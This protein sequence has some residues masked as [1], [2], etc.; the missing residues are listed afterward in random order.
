[1]YLNL[2]S[3]NEKRNRFNTCKI[4]SW[5]LTSHQSTSKAEDILCI[6]PR[7]RFLT[8]DD[9]TYVHFAVSQLCYILKTSVVKTIIKIEVHE[10]VVTAKLREISNLPKERREI[11]FVKNL[12]ERVCS[13]LKT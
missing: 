10:D 3:T 4:F 11:K 7:I 13:A 12:R 8:V 5:P 2:S 1:M 9:N 6:G